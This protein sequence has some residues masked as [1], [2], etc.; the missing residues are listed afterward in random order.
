MDVRE[1]LKLHREEFIEI[2]KESPFIVFLC[3]PKLKSSAAA[4]R[5][6]KRIKRKLE[7]EDFEVVL[8]EDDGLDNPVIHKIGVNAQDNELT[9]I[10]KRCN[11][12]VIVADSVGSFCELALFSWHFVHKEGLI[13][14]EKT[15][16]IVLLN[17]KFKDHKSY[18]N[19]GPVA[20][21]GAFGSVEFVDF[22]KYDCASLVKRLLAQR[23]I[24][25]VDNR[26]GRPRKAAP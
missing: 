25:T 13:D 17:A 4:S 20:S 8:G 10:E 23:G 1:A 6:R 24:R 19:S 9:F 16:C 3:G 7:D 26:R 2:A 12:V 18:L 21:V 22:A 14:K 15:D 5:L 11:A